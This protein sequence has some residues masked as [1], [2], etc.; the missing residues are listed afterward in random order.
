MK[1]KAF[2]A[3]KSSKA[4]NRFANLMD[5]NP[6]CIVDKIEGNSVHLGS[7]N[8]RNFFWV[9]IPNDRHWNVEL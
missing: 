2:V 5:H 9:T 4:K 8:G 7:L 3:P 1:P 6:E